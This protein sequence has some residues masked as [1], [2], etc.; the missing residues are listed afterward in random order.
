MLALTLQVPDVG[1]VCGGEAGRGLALCDPS[2]QRTAAVAAGGLA[3]LA[4]QAA[5][6]ARALRQPGNE[7][8]WMREGQNQ[9]DQEK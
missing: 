5:L 1:V 7:N 4:V 6:A 3:A 2:T 8:P 9:L